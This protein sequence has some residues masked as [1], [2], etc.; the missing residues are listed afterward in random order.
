[1]MV[2]SRIWYLVC[3][4][5]AALAFYAVSLAVGQFN[6]TLEEAMKEELKADTQ[7]IGWALQLDAR[8]HLDAFLLAS[9]DDGV[10]KALKSAAA[11]DGFAA[12]RVEAKKA[13]GRVNERLPEDLRF[14]AAFVVDREGRVVG[15]VGF[16]QAE[17]APDFELGGYPAVFDALHGFLRDDTWLIAGHVYRVSARPVEDDVTQPPLGAVVGLKEINDRYA[18]ELAKKSRS[19]LVFFH[20]D[21]KLGQASSDEQLT[22]AVF[23]VA[24]TEGAALDADDFK[25]GARTEF[26]TLLANK[27]EAAGAMF[28]RLPGEAGVLG[29][30][31]GVLRRQATHGGPMDFITTATESDKGRVKRWLIALLAL[32][33][34][35]IGIALTFLEHARPL[36]EL[37]KQAARLRK[38]EQDSFQLPRLAA[39]YRAIGSDV[40]GG[41]E[42]IVE[43]RGGVVAKKPADLQSILGPVPAQGSMS[44]FSFPGSQSQLGG[45]ASAPGSVPPPPNPAPTAP[46]SGGN[47][48][49]VAKGGFAPPPPKGAP[50][51]KGGPAPKLAP[52]APKLV[53]PSAMQLDLDPAPRGD[54]RLR[55]SFDDEDPNE[56]ATR[57]GAAPEQVLAAAAQIRGEAPPPAAGAPAGSPDISTLAEWRTVFEDF[58]STKKQCNETTEGLTFEKFQTTLRKNRDALLQR[59]G[60]KRVKFSVYVKEGKAA[61]K[62][63]PL[64]E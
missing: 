18:Q 28:V 52:P 7:V 47:G 51:P 59:H 15:H 41:I 12:A 43:G 37:R 46:A 30:S 48:P 56:E 11:K 58:L 35:L 64:K 45:P 20:G 42:R 38:G 3:A 1:M 6:R 9:S 23:D 14:D 16:G 25:D 60:T 63:T 8:R 44:A 55:R 33:M 26:R 17:S 54:D 2:L 21:R 36:A 13:I 62:A 29:A 27:S 34:A 5:A 24:S 50:A 49:P 57:V 31:Y 32:G 22:S 39:D 4:I 53:P 10:R 61:L 19:S 40:N